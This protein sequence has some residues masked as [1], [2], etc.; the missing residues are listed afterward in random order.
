[1]QLN[2]FLLS[3]YLPSTYI[4]QRN[5]YVTHLVCLF[6]PFILLSVFVSTIRSLSSTPLFHFFYQAV[7]P[8]WDSPCFPCP[9]PLSPLSISI[10]LCILYKT[11]HVSP[12]SPFLLLSAC[13]ASPYSPAVLTGMSA[14]SFPLPCQF[15]T[16]NLLLAIFPYT[17]T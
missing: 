1:M 14:A 15:W 16:C 4:C 17:E 3:L 12:L 13:I 6:S 5:V 9:P 7:S 2:L 11:H 8:L 10:C